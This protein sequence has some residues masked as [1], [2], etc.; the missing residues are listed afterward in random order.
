MTHH[1]PDVPAS[2]AETY[3]SYFVPNIF[4][5]WAAGLIDRAR[6]QPGERILDLACGTGIVARLIAG[7]LGN[8]ASITGIDLNPAM[9]DVARDRATREG[10]HIDWHV[11]SA[12]ALPLADASI[13]LV[14]IHQG[15]QFFPDTAA[16]LQEI[17]RVLARNG[18][19]ASATWTALQDNPFNAAVAAVVERHLGVPALDAPYGMGDRDVLE[20]AFAAAG[21]VDIDIDR[22][23]RR[24]ALPSPDQFMRLSLTAASAAIPAL[25]ALSDDRRSELIASV[26][27]DTAPIILQYTEGDDVVARRGAH[28]VIA[29]NGPR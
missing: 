4:R 7:R 5:P 29:R 10:W 21:F 12:D 9:I 19:I 26:L 14:V 2:P 22:I 28:V 1:E 17:R 16:A 23:E 13:D 3:E 27:A 25:R 11:A 18:R 8:E 6:P 24:V 20:G 15:L